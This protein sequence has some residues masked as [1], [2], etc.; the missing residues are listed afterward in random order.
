MLTATNVDNINSS[1]NTP[2]KLKHS[3]LFYTSLEKGVVE[4]EL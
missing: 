4:N 2:V 1:I 3:Y